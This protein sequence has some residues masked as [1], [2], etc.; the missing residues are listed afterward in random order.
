MFFTAFQTL[1]KD[2][3][4]KT[5][6]SIGELVAF[7]EKEG[8]QIPKYE[9]TYPQDIIDKVIMDLKEY[10]NTLIKQDAGLSQQIEQYIKKKEIAEEQKRNKEQAKEAGMDYVEIEDEDYAEFYENL[11]AQKEEDEKIYQEV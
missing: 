3:N 7:C 4:G 2:E 10:T 5:F 11:E 1:Q 6:D 9:I 8:G